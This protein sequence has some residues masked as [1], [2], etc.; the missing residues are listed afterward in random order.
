MAKIIAAINMTIDGNCDHTAGIPD[1]ALHQHY[2]DLI[3]SGSVILYGSKTFELMKFWKAFLNEPSDEQSMNDF[4]KAIDRI[5]KLVFSNTLQDIEWESAS[6]A[7]T[8][9]ESTVLALK[10]QSSKDVLIGSRSLIIQLLNLKLIDEFQ[11]CI[12]PIIEGKGLQLF[13]DVEVKSQFRLSGTKVFDSGA[14]VLS[15]S[16]VI[17]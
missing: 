4:A 12:H 10:K 17:V 7:S 8:D 14:I 13:D 6:V 15:Y 5:P 3:N 1:E 11:L 16:P 2:T 9:L